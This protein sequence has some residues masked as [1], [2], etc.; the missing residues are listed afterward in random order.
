MNSGTLRLQFNREVAYYAK[1]IINDVEQGKRSSEEGLKALKDEQSSLL[2]QSTDIAQKGIG[3]V[4][5]AFQ[6][7]AGAGICY[8]SVGTLCFLRAL[9]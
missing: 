5:G 3:A 7:A 6:F 8:G 9:R 2:K 1:A 4:A